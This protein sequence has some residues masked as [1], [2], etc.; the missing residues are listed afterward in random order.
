MKQKNIRLRE[1]MK[2]CLVLNV[3]RKG[4][5]IIIKKCICF[6]PVKTSDLDLPCVLDQNSKLQLLTKKNC[7]ELA[8]KHRPLTC[9]HVFEIQ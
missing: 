7:A 9:I 2:K 8:S 1:S 3:N 6:Y 4:I 5:C